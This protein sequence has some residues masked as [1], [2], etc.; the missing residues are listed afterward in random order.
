MSGPATPL[1]NR[2][3]GLYRK[4]LTKFF[5]LRCMAQAWSARAINRRG[6]K[7]GSVTYSTDR[8]DEVSIRYLLYLFSV[9]DG[10]VNDFHW[11]GTASNFWSR[12][13]AKRVNLQSFFSRL[14]S[15]V[16]NLKE[17]LNYYLLHKLR[18]FGDK[19]PYQKRLIF[20]LP[21]REV[22]PAKLTNHSAR[23]NLEI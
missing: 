4:L 8:E 19:S 5:P 21:C 6:K 17:V 3:W 10:F 1:T 20:A 9:Y 23:T 14:H 11:W 22:R 2:V 18:K 16:H 7:R 12:S 15:L 13:K